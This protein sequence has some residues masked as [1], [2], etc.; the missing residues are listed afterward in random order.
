MCGPSSVAVLLLGP[1]RGADPEL[2]MARGRR[3]IG[4]SEIAM[5][6][7]E[8]GL[9]ESRCR[10]KNAAYLE[11]QFGDVAFDS[12]LGLAMRANQ[13]DGQNNLIFEF[14]S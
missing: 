6:Q 14:L 9:H 8:T 11:I 10:I 2:P 12:D 4:Q 13:A 1:S 5:T 3:T 7:E